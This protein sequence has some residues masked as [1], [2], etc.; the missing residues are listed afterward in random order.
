MFPCL[1]FQ[2]FPKRIGMRLKKYVL[3]EVVVVLFSNLPRLYNIHCPTTTFYQLQ[4]VK[5]NKHLQSRNCINYLSLW[6]ANRHNSDQGT[7]L[8]AQF[9]ENCLRAWLMLDLLWIGNWIVSLKSSEVEMSFWFPQACWLV[10]RGLESINSF[11]EGNLGELELSVLG[12]KHQTDELHQQEESRREYQ[13][14][15][16]L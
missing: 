9:K 7:G 14:P 2:V 3:S 8:T 11:V 16:H 6:A 15:H 4:T 12:T 13:D 10:G 5:P 1:C